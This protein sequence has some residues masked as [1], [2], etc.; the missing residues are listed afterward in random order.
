MQ[1][2]TLENEVIQSL[3]RQLYAEPGFSDVEVRDISE[4]TGISSRMIR[5]ALGSLSKKG[6]IYVD[7]V[8]MWGRDSMQLIHLHSD[9]YHLHPEWSKI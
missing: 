4:D 2:T 7:E 8:R 1:F 3:I 5:G 6:V 9:Y